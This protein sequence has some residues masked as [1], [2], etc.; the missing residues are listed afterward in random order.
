MS[1]LKEVFAKFHEVAEN[2]AKQFQSYL[3]AGKKVV[4]CVPVYTPE[5]V[6]H[7]MGLIPFGVWGADL[8]VEAA[9][10]YFP[11]FIPSL[12]QTALELGIKGK[13]EGM[14]ACIIPNLSDSLKAMGENWKYAVKGVPYIPMTYPQNRAI[15]AG[16][17]FTKAGYLRVARDLEK[18]TGAT[19]TDENLQKSLDIYNEH[20]QLMRRFSELCAEHDCVT[21]RMRRDVFK[22]AWFMLKEEHTALLHELLPLLEEH[23]GEQGKL[24][25]ITSGLLADHN[26]LLEILETADMTIVADDIGHE[27]RQYRV[28][29]TE[30]E[31]ALDKL[32]DKFARM[33][34]CAFLYD[35]DKKR[36]QML[37]DLAK[38]RKADGVI[39]FLTKFCDPEEFDYVPIKRALEKNEIPHVLIEID[40]QMDRFDQ[41]Q[42]AIE[43]FA[44]LLA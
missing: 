37:V 20:N 18:Y 27:S 35:V 26:N 25:I 32:V 13:F 42:T 43:T 44:D 3:N 4:G 34:Y 15:K 10:S 38:G 17:D 31:T 2:P 7:A 23:K 14:S 40:R 28:D 41:A 12:F 24:R 19:L 8:Q 39:I 11:A 29:A 36:A 6:V 22:S 5:E 16:R 1:Q 21:P 33:D 30:G 9:K